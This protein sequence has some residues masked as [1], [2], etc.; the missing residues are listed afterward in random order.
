MLISPLPP[1]TPMRRQKLSS[2]EGGGNRASA[3]LGA[4]LSRKSP[5]GWSKSKQ[6]E[7]WKQRYY[8]YFTASSLYKQQQKSGGANAFKIY[9]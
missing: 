9:S 5:H 2:D 3:A 1:G 6:E 8:S 7:A 4:A